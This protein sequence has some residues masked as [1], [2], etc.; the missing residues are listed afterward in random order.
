MKILVVDDERA[1]LDAYKHILTPSSGQPQ[2]DALRQLANSLF[3]DVA[4]TPKVPALAETE[5][6]YCC[7]GLEAVEAIKRS[8][9]EGAPFK[10]AFIDIRMPPGIDGKETARQIRRIDPN[11]NLVIVSAYS[12]H[13]VTDISAVAGPPDKIFYISKPFDAAEITQMATALANRWDFDTRQLEAL[14]SKVNELAASEARARHIASHDFLTGAPNRMSFQ[15][16]LTD[17]VRSGDKGFALALLDLD[18]FKH[19]NDTFGHGAGDDLLTN[20]YQS[21]REQVPPSAIVARLGGDEF[22]IIIDTTSIEEARKIFSSVIDVCA[23]RHSIYGNTVQIGGSIGWLLASS[24]ESSSAVDLMRFCDVALYA[25]KK[26]GRSI[27][28]LFDAAMDESTKFKQS[29]E[30]GLKHA[31]T[32]GELAV[33][34]QPIIDRNTLEP[35]GVEALLRWTSPVHGPVSPTVFIPIAEESGLIHEIG[36]WVV[37]RALED[38]LN[39]P[40]YFIS[41]NLSPRQFR[42]VDLVESL[43]QHALAAGVPHSR[44]QLEITET[45]LFDDAS[46][47]SSVLA[48]LQSLGFRIALDDFGTGYS[49]LL[50]V[51][52]FGLDCIKIDKSFVEG[53]GT[54]PNAAAIIN[55]IAHLAKGLGLTVVAEG[56]ETDAQCQALRLVGCSHLQGFLF[57]AAEELTQANLRYAGRSALKASANPPPLLVVHSAAN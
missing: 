2:E 15:R 41:I 43:C 42:R 37:R 9:A 29:I 1:V 30:S 19:V 31:I 3:S 20:V 34:Y 57:G 4:S 55:S 26:D 49:S 16:S 40:E 56:V 6:T 46:R 48:E 45:A 44:V 51:K 39:W 35:V 54:E 8:L 25:A 33:H 14:K 12:D 38:S 27:A 23:R 22:A 36:D 47:A 7:Q 53:L 32:Q 5:V 52:N 17:R 50:N 13:N 18:R 28:F 10:V 11:I 24:F 21:I